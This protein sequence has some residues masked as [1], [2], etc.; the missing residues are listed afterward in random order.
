MSLLLAIWRLAA[1]DI[2]HRPTQAMLLLLAIA[3]GAATLSLGLSLQ[4]TTNNPY[5]RTRAATN[6]PDAVA[7]AFGGGSSQGSAVS[8]PAA[9]SGGAADS[10]Q[11]SAA[12]LI[13]LEH[14]PGVV[15]YSGPFP[16]TWV[17][18][19]A[20][21]TA[22]SAEVEGR[23][24]TLTSP[25]DQPK[26][27][28][29]TWARPGGVVVEAGY[30]S[31]LNL[32]VGGQVDLGGTTFRIVGTAVTAAVP[33][34]PDICSKGAGCLL[35]NAV[36]LHNPGLVWAT[37]ADTQKI[38]SVTDGALSYYMNL[39]LTD[40]AA[41]PAFVS[42]YNANTS[43]TAPYLVSWQDL[44]VGDAEVTS[45][46]QLILFTGSWL[47]ALLAIASV[48]VLVGGRMVEQT[49]RVGL[50]KAVGGTPRFVAVV[51]LFEHALIGLCAAGV[52]LLVGW[53]AAPL[54]DS[55]G[56]GLLSAPAVPSIT[57]AT[58]GLVVALAL[59]VAVVA[60]F[61]PAIRGAGQS[62]VAAL[63]D[64]ARPPRR[65]GAIIGLSTSLPPALLLGVRLAGRR[66]RR[67][68]LSV[69]SVA[70]AA[71]GLVAVLI[72]H[73][74]LAG[75]PLG[76][77]LGPQV[78]QAT[79]LISLMM[80]ILAAVNAFF[81]AWTTALETRHAAALTR[82]LG[83]TPR[84][85]TTG[86]TVAYLAP[87]LAGALLGIPGG[88]AIYDGAKHGGGP[89]TLPS[90]VWLLALVVLTV[91]VIGVL[92]AIPTRINARQPVADVLR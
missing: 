64:S 23:S 65:V 92:T 8:G 84:Q 59:G 61:V 53:L 48:A 67:L 71:S 40:P 20:G 87:A 54:I 57:G 60:T 88:L 3:A 33:N 69:F 22:G 90:A 16:I 58:V 12:S 6:G 45:K 50:L 19:Q 9:V 77:Q 27:L 49:R 55:P 75:R 72:L 2:R 43:P 7:G 38:V 36:A 13:P 80:V 66:P 74:T 62:T 14:A 29:G 15:A 26:L 32:R 35:A 44:R 28:Q 63:E 52:G 79:T 25:V 51:L 56:A 17:T 10:G 89:T 78:T 34:Y 46:V 91:A 4:G 85:V 5:A 39:K 24:S 31:A 83:A 47:L 70:V 18:L 41:A 73:A 68:V 76:P 86:L 81:I 11:P 21:Q 30:A 82:A 1:R 37:E 42:R